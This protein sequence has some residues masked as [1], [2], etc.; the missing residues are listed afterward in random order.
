MKFPDDET[1]RRLREFERLRPTREQQQQI[2]ALSRMSNAERRAM[3]EV[4]RPTSYAERIAKEK[5]NELMA[6]ESLTGRSARRE[7]EAYAH[8]HMFDLF[9]GAGSALRP[10]M[11]EFFLSNAQQA[12]MEALKTLSYPALNRSVSEAAA[13]LL[14]QQEHV[15][16]SATMH[17]VRNL[18][19]PDNATFQA[20]R[21]DAFANNLMEYVRRAAE[22]SEATEEAIEEL[23]RIVEKKVAELPRGRVSMDALLS[24]AVA[25]ILFLANIVYLEMKENQQPKP[26]LLTPEQIERLIQSIEKSKTLAP[27]DDKA[28]YYIVQRQVCIRVKPNN[29]SAKVAVLYP[30]QKVRLEKAAHRWIYVEY[31]DFIEGI[32]K[33]GW[34][35]KKYLKRLQ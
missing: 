1:L 16:R 7:M 32:P 34:V 21:R 8:R 4:T 11:T 26:N 10:V 2:D 23:K 31:F 18:W 9:S 30:N 13:V 35:N 28:D 5:M 19:R 20:F 25:V 27:P 3:D 14:S 12:A 15:L 24:I 29:R 22:S 6:F 33:M 17:V